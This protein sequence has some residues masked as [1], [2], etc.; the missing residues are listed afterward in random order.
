MARNQMFEG[1]VPAG[2][3]W[4]AAKTLA[5]GDSGEW[6][7][8]VRGKAADGWINTKL[9]FDGRRKRKANFW[10]N[11]NFEIGRFA[12]NHDSRLLGAEDEYSQLRRE[13]IEAVHEIAGLAGAA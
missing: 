5:D 9:V 10:L 1:N 13:F 7:L 4:W 11:Y 2:D 12:A 6:I 3:D 8:F